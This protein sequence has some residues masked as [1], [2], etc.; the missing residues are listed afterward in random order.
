MKAGVFDGATRGVA[1]IW[2]PLIKNPQRVSNEFMSVVD[3]LPTFL[4]AAG[5]KILH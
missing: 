4:S 2:S 5:K 3:W 1:A